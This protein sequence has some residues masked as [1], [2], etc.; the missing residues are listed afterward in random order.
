MPVYFK[1]VS[2]KKVIGLFIVFSSFNAVAF[3]HVS[4]VLPSG[5]IIICKNS[6]Q[7]RNGDVVESYKLKN[8]SSRTD[9]TKVKI[10]EFKLPAVGEKVKI[11]HTSVV[12]KNKSDLSFVNS[13]DGEAI[14]IEPNLTNELRTQ[15]TYPYRAIH[16]ET[17]V[18]FTQ[19][20]M[21]RVRNECIVASPIGSAKFHNR[22]LVK[23]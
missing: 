13:E 8:P 7:V 12:R 9:K 18:A 20:E 16:Q 3:D 17:Q 22:D 23:F 1:G 5:K 19:E 2:M 4:D 14:V 21:E 6:D 15:I 10:N 11:I